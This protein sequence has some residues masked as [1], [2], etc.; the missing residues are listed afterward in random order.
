MKK[1]EGITLATIRK[2]KMSKTNKLMAVLAMVGLSAGITSAAPVSWTGTGGD[3]QWYTD[4]NWDTGTAPVIDGTDNVSITSAAVTYTRSGT[5]ML[6]DDGSSL[7]LDGASLTQTTTHYIHYDHGSAFTLLNGSYLNSAGTY[8]LKTH[9]AGANFVVDNSTM[10]VRNVWADDHVTLALSNGS[11]VNLLGRETRLKNGSLF[12]VTDS[13]LNLRNVAFQLYNETSAYINVNDGAQVN[14]LNTDLMGT[15][16]ITKGYDSMVNFAAGST[17]SVFIDNLTEAQ[18]ETMIGEGKFGVDGTGSTTLGD[19]IYSTSGSG[20]TMAIPEPPPEEIG[21]ITIANIPEGVTIT[22][23]SAA[24]QDYDVQSK[25]SLISQ[26]TW[27][28]LASVVGSGSSMTVT[29][30][31]DNAESFYQVV[32]PTP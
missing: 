23:D 27:D 9:G 29:S 5:D 32:T 22:W 4:T 19:Y 11:T 18:L 28:T 31:V 21:T 6:W 2:N 16:V 30:T 13:T 10:S 3:G 15:D 1:L 20:V 7:I 17:G 14:L 25:S 12:D 26:L 24:G 8:D